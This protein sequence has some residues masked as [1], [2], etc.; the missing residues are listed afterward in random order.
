MASAQAA[1]AADPGCVVC[2]IVADHLQCRHA[3]EP[4]C[5]QIDAAQPSGA[6][7]QQVAL[8]LMAE[9]CNAHTQWFTCAVS[10]RARS[11]TSPA[12]TSAYRYASRCRASSPYC[13][14]TTGRSGSDKS[15][16]C[17][18]ALTHG[19]LSTSCADSGY[20]WSNLL[21]GSTLRGPSWGVACAACIK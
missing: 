4:S 20:V 9:A 3:A 8:H 10:L 19:S 12:A 21:P 17:T 7:M 16:G 11:L 2:R 14:A 13:I 15:R 18:S 6:N 1:P 5:E